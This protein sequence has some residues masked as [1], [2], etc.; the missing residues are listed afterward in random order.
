M[1][2]Y[3]IFVHIKS[4]QSSCD[5]VRQRCHCH[6]A[7]HARRVCS[8]HTSN[9]SCSASPSAAA[10]CRMCTRCCT[11]NCARHFIHVRSCGSCWCARCCVW[12]CSVQIKCS[13]TLM[14]ALV[15]TASGV[16]L[17]LK[18]PSLWQPTCFTINGE[19]RLTSFKV[20]LH[21]DNTNSLWANQT[22]DPPLDRWSKFKEPPPPPPNL[23]FIL[24]SFLL[25][26]FYAS[27]W[28]VMSFLKAF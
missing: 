17:T 9:R 22:P 6:C 12:T 27:S 1:H 14:F 3:S 4:N 20:E 10:A 19:T 18:W 13:S 21:N 8:K 5:P 26:S 11:R 23:L 15:S 25:V 28:I 16:G 7:K 2:T 24:I